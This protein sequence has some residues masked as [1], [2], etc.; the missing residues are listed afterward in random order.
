MKL[1]EKKECPVL[2]KMK[3][4][5]GQFQ[6]FGIKRTD[7]RYVDGMREKVA[8]L[9][10]G[11]E[12]GSNQRP[13]AQQILLGLRLC[14]VEKALGSLQRSKQDLDLDPLEKRRRR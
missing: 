4:R 12:E 13:V 7:S 14:H 8:N 3:Y 6:R 1:N 9:A 5:T 2:M 10:F 11:T